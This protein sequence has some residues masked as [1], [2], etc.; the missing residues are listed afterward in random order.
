MASAA[1]PKSK[2][3]SPFITLSVRETVGWSL[4]LLVLFAWMFF[5]GILVG[6]GSVEVALYPTPLQQELMAGEPR[7]NVAR[8]GLE[9]ATETPEVELT[10][11]KKVG[12]SEEAVTKRK[13][14]SKKQELRSFTPAEVARV[15]PQ[16]TASVKRMPSASPKAKP[17]APSTK[18]GYT[19]QVAAHASEDAAKR[20][21]AQLSAKGF[22]VYVVSGV[23]TKGRTWHRVRVGH[24]NK[25]E[26]AL[27]ELSRMTVFKKRA[28]VV[29]L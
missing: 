1:T 15:L 29:K 24:Y 3:T 19:I 28:Y 26:A 11:L 18:S 9:G 20:E 17:K 8:L 21:A 5:L 4:A 10:F 2:S 6:R 13:Q 25:K 12:R 22:P 16:E 14:V 7:Q 23:D 27:K